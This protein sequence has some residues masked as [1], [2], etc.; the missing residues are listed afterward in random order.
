MHIHIVHHVRK[1]GS[2]R[3]EIDKFAVRGSSAIVDQIDNL[4]LIRRNLDKERLAEERELT[5]T[6]DQD[7]ADA[8]LR[9]SKQRNGDFMGLVPLWFDKRGAVFCTSAE[10]ALPRLLTDPALPADCLDVSEL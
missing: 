2:E 1:A 7:S 4:V 8:L 5:P 3:D 10:R 9:I 6:E